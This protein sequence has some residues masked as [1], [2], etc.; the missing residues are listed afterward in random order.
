[1]QSIA[2]NISFTLPQG[3]QVLHNL[4]LSVSNGEK[5]ALAGDNGTGKSTLI[6]I[7]AGVL[8]PQTGSVYRNGKTWFAPQ[9][10]GQFDNLTVA[11]ILK[12]HLKT[13]A[14]KAIEQGSAD[15]RDFETLADDWNIHERLRTALE[16]WELADIHADTPFHSLSS[17]Q[18]TK[19]FL[20]GTALHNPDMVLM[21]EPTNHLDRAGREKLYRLIRETSSTL[22]IVSHDRELLELCNPIY[23]LSSA[24]V[25]AY[26]GNYSFYKAQ[27]KIEM[28]A[29]DQKIEHAKKEISTARKKHHDAMRRKQKMDARSAKKG[30]TANLPPIVK[31]ARGSKAENSASRLNEVHTNK[32]K[33]E[34]AHL[35]QLTQLKRESKQASLSVSNSSLHTGKI[36]FEAKQMNIGWPDSGCLWETP[37]SFVIKSGER[38]RISGRNGSGKST[39]LHTL[40]Q[41]LKPAFGELSFHADS[42]FLLD[43]EYQLINRKRSVLEQAKR[44]NENQK[45]DHELKTLLVRFL[46]E[47]S[48]WDQ[49]CQTL[50]GG[51]MMRLSLCCLTLQS[52]QPDVIILD[53]PTNNL[54]LSN[55]QIL[56]ETIANYQ[57][58]LLVVSHDDWFIKEIGISRELSLS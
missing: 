41:Q 50:S 1:M 3:K 48:V 56:T 16:H 10:F 58:T 33:A 39:L 54:D 47:P 9:H 17:G 6:R 45:P 11:Q 55:I 53:E 26:G 28:E 25:Q 15:P 8:T 52:N 20:A 43:Q 5:A 38:I 2:E 14:L 51:E 13:E 37:R 49:P 4:S 31:N 42:V 12:I 35:K 40:T 18:K 21:D 57:G 7:L 23:E 29:L 44:F 32:I 19:L 46:F 34:K 30:K 24:G 22:F 27:K 36:L